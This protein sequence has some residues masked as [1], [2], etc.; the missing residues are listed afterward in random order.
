MMRILLIMPDAHMHK[1]RIGAV[2]A[3]HARGAADP[4]H[5][6]CAGS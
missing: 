6:G 4:H 5:A 1:L 2:R 3:L